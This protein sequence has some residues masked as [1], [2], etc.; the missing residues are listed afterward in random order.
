[1]LYEIEETIYILGDK[2]MFSYIH[3]TNNLLCYLKMIED[4]MH[5]SNC[6]HEMHSLAIL[7]VADQAGLVFCDHAGPPCA[8]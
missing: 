3:G 5:T 8:L 6:I 7:P 2:L 4:T 1:M